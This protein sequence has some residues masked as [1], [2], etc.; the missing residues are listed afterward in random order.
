[1]GWIKLHRTIKDHWIWQ[2][3][4]KL[5]WWLDL[6]LSVNHAPSKVL[7][8]VDLVE[9]GRGQSIRSLS[10]WANDWRVSKDTARH[11]F[12][13]L[14]KDGMISR[15]SL[16]RTTRITVLNYDNYQAISTVDEAKT[17]GIILHENPHE[18]RTNF[19][20]L[21]CCAS[22]SYIEDSHELRTNAVRSLAT[23]K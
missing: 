15:E 12:E 16:G 23:N 7:V 17:G 19:A 1:M 21:N 4:T 22:A 18:I 2:D 14:E 10:S 5:K 6:L 20:R 11:F 3:A 8:G 9:C 13:A